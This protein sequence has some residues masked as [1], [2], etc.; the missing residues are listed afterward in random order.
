MPSD[1]RLA[2]EPPPLGGDGRPFDPPLSVLILG[3]EFDF[4][5]GQGASTRVYLYAKGMVEAGADVRVVSLLQPALGP[6]GDDGPALGTYDG[7]AYEYACGTRVRPASFLRRRW[8][9]LR[10]AVRIVSLVREVATRSSGRYVLLVYSHKTSWIAGLA[11]LARFTGGASVWDLCEFPLVNRPRTIQT[12]VHRAV[13]MFLVCRL[14]DGV[15]PISTYLESYVKQTPGATLPMLRVPVMVD[16]ALFSRVADVAS[17]QGARRV[18]YCGTLRRV[19]EVETVMRI[20]AEATLGLPD[21]RLT[22]VGG[23][24]AQARIRA[25]SFAR[26][27]DLAGRVELL[28]RIEREE[29]A[30]RMLAAEVLVLPRAA[31]LFSQAGLAN[32]LG[33][34]LA[35]GRPV[36]VTA[37]GDVGLYLDDGVDA[38]LVE[39]GDDATFAARLRYALEHPDEAAAVGARG[40]EVAQ[41]EFD[42]RVHGAR[43]FAFMSSLV[44]PRL[45]T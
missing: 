30:A 33:E 6:S 3:T 41:R 5:Q 8:L 20:F 10:R 22:I 37:T 43:L 14:C 18:L 15:I 44:P 27:L 35:S 25:D 11:L 19:D 13:R 17:P 21:V 39:P 24:P 2:P 26:S 42:Y 9:S 38:Y 4:P 28:E 45:T 12:S 32:K 23:G 31:G 7:L 34:Y 16:P 40:R 29:L 36:V 1:R